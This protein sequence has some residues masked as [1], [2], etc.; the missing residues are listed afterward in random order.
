MVNFT[1]VINSSLHSCTAVLKYNKLT[2]LWTQQQFFSLGSKYSPAIRLS[3][4]HFFTAAV[5]ELYRYY[6]CEV[7][8]HYQS[9]QHD[10]KS[11]RFLPPKLWYR[12]WILMFWSNL[13]LPSSELKCV[14]WGSHWNR[15]IVRKVGLSRLFSCSPFL[16]A[17]TMFYVLFPSD[18]SEWPSF[19][20][21]WLDNP[22]DSSPYT[23]QSWRWWK[24]NAKGLSSR[25][26]WVATD[27][28][29]CIST[30]HLNV[31]NA[32]WDDFSS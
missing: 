17:Q 15:Q 4:I 23:F 9:A 19:L 11:V 14:G 12:K 24:H 13:L 20:A 27:L 1:S 3:S 28:S 18:G 7:N 26:I 29:N 2:W 21:T 22:T 25:V 5:H 32:K 16:L 8:M 6:S 31:S 30:L 10:K